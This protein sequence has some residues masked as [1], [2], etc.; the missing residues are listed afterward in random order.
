MEKAEKGAFH[1]G[2]KE[3]DFIRWMEHTKAKC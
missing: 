1:K 3:T 2:Q